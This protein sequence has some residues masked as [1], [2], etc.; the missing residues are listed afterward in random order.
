MEKSIDVRVLMG[1]GL[2]VYWRRGEPESRVGN[3][4]IF[5]V[6]GRLGGALESD[7]C[8][9]IDLIIESLHRKKGRKMRFCVV[10]A[11]CSLG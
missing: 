7:V 11:V 5:L 8:D 9:C 10:V 3:T 2:V 1:E 6:A 4:N